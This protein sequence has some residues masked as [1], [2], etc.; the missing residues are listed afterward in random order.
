MNAPHERGIVVELM[1]IQL[2]PTFNG[3]ANERH[4]RDMDETVRDL[5]VFDYVY[6]S[7]EEQEEGTGDA[8]DVVERT[9]AQARLP[10]HHYRQG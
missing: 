2:H 9:M 3:S 5:A 7:G 8:D 6:D 1:V 10:I 4:G